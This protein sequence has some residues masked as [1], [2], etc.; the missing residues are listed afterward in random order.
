MDEALANALKEKKDL[1]QRLAEINQFLRLYEQFSPKNQDANASDPPVDKSTQ[2]ERVI[3]RVIHHRP[4]KGPKVVAAMA[5]E[6]L[7]HLGQPMSR[8]DLA[9]ELEFRNVYLPGRDHEDRSRYVGTIMW[10]HRKDLF[11]NVKKRGYWLKGV[12]IPDTEEEKRELR[13]EGRSL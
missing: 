8:G 11:E 12:P 5:A 10:R 2:V 3:H 13:L 7:R 9:K 4:R 6:I 1:E